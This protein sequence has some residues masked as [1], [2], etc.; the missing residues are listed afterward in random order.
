LS[1]QQNIFGHNYDVDRLILLMIENVL[2]ADRCIQ[3][4]D[5]RY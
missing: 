1:R 2:A 3:N 5:T 4:G